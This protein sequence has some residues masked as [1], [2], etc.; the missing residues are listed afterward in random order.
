MSYICATN[1]R[2]TLL[3]HIQIVESRNLVDLFL[4]NLK[5]IYPSIYDDRI[6]MRLQEELLHVVKRG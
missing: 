4:K 2:Y 5:Y 3:L 1:H 6:V